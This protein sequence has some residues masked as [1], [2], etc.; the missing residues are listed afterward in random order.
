ME[1]VAYVERYAY[2]LISTLS[3]EKVDHVFTAGGASNSDTWLRIRSAVMNKPVYKMKYVS[4]AVG[5][6]IVAASKTWFNSLSTATKALV[7]TEKL[8]TPEK[9]LSEKYESLYH[10]FID[11]LKAREYIQP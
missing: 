6:A 10:I 11:E 9:E 8:I 2:E 4:G 5:A 3:G 1:G 7:Q